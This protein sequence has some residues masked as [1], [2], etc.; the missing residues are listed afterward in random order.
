MSNKE[1]E[2]SFLS[3]LSSGLSGDE[4]LL[5]TLQAMI[6]AEISMRRQELGLSQKDFAK[7]MRVSQGL[8]SRW[9]AGEANYTL[10]TL[11]K[12]ASALGLELQSPIVSQPPK[13]YPVGFSNVVLF[14]NHPSWST[15][16]FSSDP[17]TQSVTHSDLERKEM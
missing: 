11:V 5:A 2:R 9:E 17:I 10:S 7:K 8:V 4:L 1:V 12:I 16:S 13:V 6:A 3:A 14:P 15:T